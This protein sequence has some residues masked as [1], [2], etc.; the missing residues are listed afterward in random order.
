MGSSNNN[1]I[2]DGR[3]IN[4]KGLTKKYSFYFNTKIQNV[5]FYQAG[6][7]GHKKI[8]NFLQILQFYFIF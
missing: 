7:L 6:W 3:K 2:Y 5:N 8:H 1:H 4:I